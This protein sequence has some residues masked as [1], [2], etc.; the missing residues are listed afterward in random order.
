MQTKKG[1]KP[2]KPSGKDLKLFNDYHEN[3]YKIKEYI[4]K[5]KKQ[6]RIK[7]KVE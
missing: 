6:L 3:I 4:Y 1:L 2:S 7:I 5:Y